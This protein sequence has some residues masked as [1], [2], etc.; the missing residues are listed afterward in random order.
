MRFRLFLAPL[1]AAACAPAPPLEP[2]AAVPPEPEAAPAVQQARVNVGCPEST[3][4]GF[5]PEQVR[6]E[7]ICHV[8]L[9]LGPAAAEQALAAGS[10]LMATYHHGLPK[11]LQRPDGSWGWEGPMANALILAGG[12]WKGWKAG[13]AKPLAPAPA[14]E[15]E[16]ILADP[17]FW[18]EEAYVRPTCTDAGAR[19]LVVRHG[20]RRTVRQQSCGGRGL[21]GRLFDLV[22][23]GA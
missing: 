11:P 17:A 2:E 23:A 10:A 12:G 4:P 20:S 5:D 7:V 14:A 6:R 1:L 21:T 13:A 3:A 22:L 9:R 15:V 18:R 16:R 19:R 8:G